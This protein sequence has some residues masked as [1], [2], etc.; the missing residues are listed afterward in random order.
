VNLEQGGVARSSWEQMDLITSV[1]FVFLTLGIVWV[2]FRIV[3]YVQTQRVREQGWYQMLPDEKFH[4]C[5]RELKQTAEKSRS[6]GS[7][8][9]R[10][11]QQKT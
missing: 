2:I 10:D 3:K 4:E 1:Y 6:P 7:P 5:L 8:E 11:E 9:T